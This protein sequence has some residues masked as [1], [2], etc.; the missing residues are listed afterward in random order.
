MGAGVS[1]RRAFAI[2]LLLHLLLGAAAGAALRG[3]ESP[4]DPAPDEGE[5]A[6]VFNL[7]D[8]AA[9]ML[10][11]ET[12]APPVEGQGD[13]GA[14]GRRSGRRAPREVTDD[15][16]PQREQTPLPETAHEGSMPTAETATATATRRRA[17]VVPGR[18]SPR[19]LAALVG[20]EA[21]DLEQ[22]VLQGMFSAMHKYALQQPSPAASTYRELLRAWVDGLMGYPYPVL[23]DLA[24]FA[25]QRFIGGIRI[26]VAADGSFRLDDIWLYQGIDDPAGRLAGYYRR[27]IRDATVHRFLPPSDANLP[28]PHALEYRIVNPRAR[29]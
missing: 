11:D 29:R 18:L 5:R 8:P 1:L 7:V 4:A 25:D 27:V 23:E 20:L 14:V 3:L 10:G 26:E 9:A 16:A 6:V 22:E 28:A 24:R 17:A 13:G 2:S 15:A 12:V 19:E 21:D